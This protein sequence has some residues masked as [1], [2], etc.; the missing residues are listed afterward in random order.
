M[1]ISV[2]FEPSRIFITLYET[3]CSKALQQCLDSPTFASQLCNVVKTSFIDAYK[4]LETGRNAADIHRSNLSISSNRWSNIRTNRC[5]LICIAAKPEHVL[6]CG[7]SM[8]D[9]CVRI[10][11]QPLN[12]SHNTFQI[13]SCIICDIDTNLLVQLKPPTA[14]LRILTVDGGGVRGVVPL[15]FLRI[16]Q[17]ILGKEC[18]IYNLF[19]LAFGTSAGQY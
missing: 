14:G 15:E 7:H 4:Q 9:N 18:Q 8:C 10:F 13:S 6:N 3:A 19:D 11:G 1:L 2:G 16:L 5:C 12:S 17:A